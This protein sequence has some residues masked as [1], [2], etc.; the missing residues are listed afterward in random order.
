MHD[1]LKIDSPYNTYM[2]AALPPGPIANPGMVALSA[3]ANPAETDYY[4]FVL[5]DPAAGRHTFSKNFDQHIRAK[6]LYTKKAP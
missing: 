4:Y 2:W 6:N 5:T 1:D 3:A